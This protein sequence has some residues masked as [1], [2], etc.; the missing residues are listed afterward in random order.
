MPEPQRSKITIT[1]DQRDALYDALIL[2]LS[3]IGDVALAVERADF[4]AADRLGRAYADDLT[5]VLDDLGWGP[6][7]GGVE[8]T[9]PREVL[10]RAL[11]RVRDW[12]Q[13]EERDEAKERAQ[14]AQS[15]RQNRIVY[16]TCDRVLRALD[17]A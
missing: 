4:E 14:L 10:W 15:H 13:D 12:A 7:G 5:L 9:A 17:R 16:E 2:H 11:S 8:L 3:G 6:H 1:A